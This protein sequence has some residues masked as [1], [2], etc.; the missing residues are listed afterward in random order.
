M[1]KPKCLY[2]GR[3]AEKLYYFSKLYQSG[4]NTLESPILSCEECSPK[5]RQDLSV[6]RGGI[7]GI[8]CRTFKEISQMSEKQIGWFCSKKGKE[9][10]H[11]ANKPWRSLIFRIHYLNQPPKKKNAITL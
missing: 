6:D 11:L 3:D 2:C 7:Q 4:K 9:A 5:A 10:N 1:E 8:F